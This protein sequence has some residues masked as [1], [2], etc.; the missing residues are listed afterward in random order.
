MSLAQHF[1]NWLPVF[2]ELSCH[3]VHISQGMPHTL[4]SDPAEPKVR[5]LDK[6]NYHYPEL[7]HSL[8]GPLIRFPNHSAGN[9]LTG[10]STPWPSG[11]PAE[12]QIF[13]SSILSLCLGTLLECTCI[14]LYV[15]AQTPARGGHYYKC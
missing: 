13:S 2:S 5:S 7:A 10:T 15:S 6:P 4:H 8:L 12:L 9:S 14:L 11:L 3:T 1:L